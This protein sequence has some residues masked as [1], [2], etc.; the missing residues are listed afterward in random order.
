MEA[1]EPDWIDRV[2]VSR[3][4]VSTPDILE[5]LLSDETYERNRKPANFLIAAH[6]RY[7]G[8]PDGIDP[9]Q[10]HLVAP[11]ERDST[12]WLD[13][14]WIDK[15]SGLVYR[16]TTTG[17]PTPTVARVRSFHDVL[18]AYATHT[19]PKSCGPD[20]EP[21][22]RRSVGLLV[23]RPLRVR[24]AHESGKEANKLEELEAG[25][26]KRLGEVLEQHD[27]RRELWI[28]LRP[29]VRQLERTE[30]A[31]AMGISGRQL[32]NLLSGRSAPNL[33]SLQNLMTALLPTA[34]E[35]HGSGYGL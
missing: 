24:L 26:I 20:G 33:R 11:F 1:K 16:V 2:P 21:C 23:R 5:P 7:F 19:E 30:A 15:Y 22:N 14:D 6:V 29:I 3:L 35:R 25:H 27:D 8:H 9:L 10:F 34:T 4:Q 18:A 31:K 17:Q 12:R 32:R 13:M 28:Q